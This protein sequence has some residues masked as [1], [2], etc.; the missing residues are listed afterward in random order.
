MPLAY[1]H[2][3]AASLLNC[4]LNELALAHLWWAGSGTL[5]ADALLWLAGLYAAP[6][7]IGFFAMRALMVRYANRRR[8]SVLYWSHPSS[9]FW[10][11]L[12]LPSLVAFI[13]W[14]TEV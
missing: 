14:G 8:R 11:N 3:L 13:A 6:S 4:V 2:L 10:N 1:K 9:D 7:L 12:L 5:P